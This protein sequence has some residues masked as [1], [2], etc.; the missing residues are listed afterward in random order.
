MIRLI[1][2]LIMMYKINIKYI[3]IFEHHEGS[4]VSKKI[5]KTY[6]IG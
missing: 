4:T 2:R 6:I 1:Y 5:L 3:Y